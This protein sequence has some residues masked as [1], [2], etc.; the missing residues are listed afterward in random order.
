MLRVSVCADDEFQCDGT[1][2]IPKWQRC[3]Q[4]NNCLDRTDEQNCP[5]TTGKPIVVLVPAVSCD[6]KS[7]FLFP[8]ERRVF[9]SLIAYRAQVKVTMQTQCRDRTPQTRR[10]SN[11]VLYVVCKYVVRAFLVAR[12][13]YRAAPGQRQHGVCTPNGRTR[14]K[15]FWFPAKIPFCVFSVGLATNAWTTQRNDGNRAR[16]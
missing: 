12:P 8:S 14:L 13:K 5:R 15:S 3:N 11:G 16:T 7:F 1:K 9:S 6:A 4:E 2:C 10:Y